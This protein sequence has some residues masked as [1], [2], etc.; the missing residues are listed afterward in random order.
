HGTSA[1]PGALRCPSIQPERRSRSW[2]SDPISTRPITTSVMVIP[3][4]KRW[5]ASSSSSGETIF[6]AARGGRAVEA[7]PRRRP[8]HTDS[9]AADGAGP[10]RLAPAL[11]LRPPRRDGR[12]G[13]GA[14][15]AIL[16]DQVAL[17]G[18]A[19]GDARLAVLP[20]LRGRG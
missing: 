10:R 18:D 3:I 17:G 1:H 2:D 13:A 20:D 14:A 9:P 4:W 19:A 11:G 16:A 7:G 6:A 12:G 8:R 5:Y 15:E